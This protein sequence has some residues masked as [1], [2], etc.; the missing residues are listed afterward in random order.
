MGVVLHVELLSWFG[1]RRRLWYYSLFSSF[2]FTCIYSLDE[3]CLH[4]N[5]TDGYHI[6]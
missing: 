2:E 6:V 5:E 4:V 3:S 1:A